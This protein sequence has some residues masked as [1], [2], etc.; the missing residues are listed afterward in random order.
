M[1][2]AFVL[3]EAS[4][5]GASRVAGLLAAAVK[6]HHETHIICMREGPLIPWFE[7]CVGPESVRLLGS[8]W[9]SGVRSLEERISAAESV[10]REERS[11]VVYVSSFAASEFIMA[12]KSMEKVV[13]VH[14]HE[15]ADKLQRLI[16]DGLASVDTVSFCDA[17]LLAAERL[18][19]DLVDVFGIVPE[20]IFVL[21]TAVD[22]KDI[23]DL[24]GHNTSIAATAVGDPFI[25][26]EDRLLIGMVGQASKSKGADLFFELAKV[27]PEHDFMWVGNW[28]PPEAEENP[29]FQDFSG[30]QLSNFFVSGGVNNPY[31]FMSKFDL[32]FLS[33]RS[34]ANPLAMTEAL[35]L[36]V[37][38]LA[39]SK[40]IA[41]QSLIARHAI[42]CYGHTNVDDA[43]RVVR[44]LNVAELRSA[45]LKSSWGDD[46]RQRFDIR[47]K[48]GRVIAL[49]ES[50]P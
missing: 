12:A 28:A 46:D 21:G 31:Q 41:D 40:T 18:G 5:S 23:P 3:P 16:T 35:A 29:A 10:L 50:F 33:S 13:V 36:D 37:P 34:D 42:L 32:F 20:R 26:A 39:F 19:K 8:N 11:D 47:R 22:F 45:G 1:R 7:H 38:V 49:L 27:V 15:D 17:V 6:E 14:A 24:S 44:A 25:L 4:Y 48:A 30:T 2:I 43:A 9:N